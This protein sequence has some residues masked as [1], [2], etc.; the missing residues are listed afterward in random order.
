MA[1]SLVKFLNRQGGNGRG[2]LYWGRSDVDGLPYRGF[3]APNLTEEE[4][5]DRVVRV[6]DPHNGTFHTWIPE[7]N[8][9]FLEVMD[10]NLNGWAGVL[11]QDNWKE[12]VEI[13]GQ[14]QLR[15]VHY[16]VWAEYYL[17]DGS[18]TTAHNPMEMSHGQGNSFNHPF[19]GS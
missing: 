14:V 16:V 15:H 18:R 7:E 4:Y 17:E 6:A 5:E 8:A 1:N 12:K 11:F 2:K 13:D 9:A 3:N 10:K 19:P